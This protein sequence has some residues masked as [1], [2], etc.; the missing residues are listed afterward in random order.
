MLSVEAPAIILTCVT[1]WQVIS[2]YV[3]ESLGQMIIAA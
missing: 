3:F 2:G 1:V